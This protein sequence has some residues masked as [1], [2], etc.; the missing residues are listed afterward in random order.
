MLKFAIDFQGPIALR[1]PRGEAYDELREYR[2]PI[3]FGKA[4][5]IY[6]EKGIVLVAVG[7][8]VK[9]ALTVRESLAKK[10]FACSVINARFVKPVDTEILDEAAKD[11]RLIVTM[12]EN[13]ASGGFGEKVRAY[14]DKAYPEKKLLTIHI[15]DEYVEHGNVEILR[16]EVGIDAATVEDRIL[17]L[18]R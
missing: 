4:E 18:V 15:P 9:S 14:L 16:R 10:G 1:Y 13:V 11:H 2:E 7:S 17:E 5:W 12:E 3:Q 8:M 6:H